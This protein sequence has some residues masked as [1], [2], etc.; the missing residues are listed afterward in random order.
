MKKL[1]LIIIFISSSYA[2]AE[3]QLPNCQGDDVTKFNKCFAEVSY[4]NG[5]IYAGQFKDGKRHGQGT[6][7]FANGDRIRR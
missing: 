3:S 5:D 4:N 6:Y 1:I 2:L 7:T